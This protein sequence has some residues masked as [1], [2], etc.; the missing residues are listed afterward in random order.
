MQETPKT[1]RGYSR[2][3]V[4]KAFPLAAAGALI[5]GVATRVAS[6]ISRRR[7][8]AAGLPEGSIFSPRSDRS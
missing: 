6:P 1:E 2:R 3:Q 8:E 5:A 7:R 4:L